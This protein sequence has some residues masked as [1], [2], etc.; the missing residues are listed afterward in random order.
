MTCNGYR[1]DE[2]WL[3]ASTI[4]NDNWLL[5]SMEQLLYDGDL[6]SDSLADLVT[7]HLNEN[8]NDSLL[9]E[10]VTGWFVGS[11]DWAGIVQSVTEEWDARVENIK[12]TAG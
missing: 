11:V 1:N 3:V 8:I 4:D 7:G 9:L 5:E 6:D 12:I 10:E 2:T